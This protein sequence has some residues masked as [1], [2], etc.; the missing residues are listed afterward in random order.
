MNWKDK[1]KKVKQ[2]DRKMKAQTKKKRKH[3]KQ[4]AL[5]KRI[6]SERKNKENQSKYHER[7]NSSATEGCTHKCV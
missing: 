2:V 1:Q 7:A 4:T 3:T 5:E 6:K